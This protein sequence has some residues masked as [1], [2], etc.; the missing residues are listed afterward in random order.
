MREQIGG[1]MVREM[2]KAAEMN[3]KTTREE[4]TEMKNTKTE[5]KTYNCAVSLSKEYTITANTPEEARD[6]AA[7]MFMAEATDENPHEL[8]PAIN[9]RYADEVNGTEKEDEICYELYYEDGTGYH[10]DNYETIDDILE[11]ISI[12]YRLTLEEENELED[13]I[14]DL[15]E[16]DDDDLDV[17]EYDLPFVN[18][19]VWRI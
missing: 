16:R 18:L 5:P 7:M 6:K 13:K 1:M 9:V 11:D 19:E 3:A 15:L 2:L 14:I 8:F 17:I 12:R 4:K 10:S